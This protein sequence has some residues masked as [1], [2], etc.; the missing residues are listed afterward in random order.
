MQK[1]ATTTT[2]NNRQTDTAARGSLTTTS[3]TTTTN[4]TIKEL[5]TPIDKSRQQ[6][7]STTSFHRQKSKQQQQQKQQHIEHSVSGSISSNDLTRS[8]DSRQLQQQQQQQQLNGL[9]NTH[10][11]SP[12]RSITSV[13]LRNYSY[14][15]KNDFAHNNRAVIAH[16][17]DE[18][19]QLFATEHFLANNRNDC[20]QTIYNK[21][22]GDITVYK[23]KLDPAVRRQQQNKSSEASAQLGQD[24]QTIN[25]QHGGEVVM[26]HNGSAVKNNSHNNYNNNHCDQ[27]RVSSSK[28]STLQTKSNINAFAGQQHR[29]SN[30]YHYPSEGRYEHGQL[31]ATSRLTPSLSS[32]CVTQPTG[33]FVN[34]YPPTRQMQ[35]PPTS[36][37]QY[38]NYSFH[39][40]LY[41]QRSP[42]SHQQQQ[43]YFNQQHSNQYPS[44]VQSPAFSRQSS[45]RYTYAKLPPQQLTHGRLAEAVNI[46]ESDQEHILPISLTPKP[47][48]KFTRSQT[49]H[50]LSSK[51]PNN[52]YEQRQDPTKLDDD[53]QLEDA[54]DLRRGSLRCMAS[55]GDLLRRDIVRYCDGGRDNPFKPDTEL[56]WEAD[57]MVKLMKRGY[58]IAE[59]TRLVEAAKSYKFDNGNHHP[60]NQR[61]PSRAGQ[62]AET[63]GAPNQREDRRGHAQEKKCN[64]LSGREDLSVAKAECDRGICRR[65]SVNQLDEKRSECKQVWADTLKRTK[66]MPKFT[67]ND[68]DSL[69]KLITSIENEISSLLERDKSKDK[70]K[71]VKCNEK[72]AEGKIGNLYASSRIDN[73]P[74]YGRKTSK[75]DRVGLRSDIET[76]KIVEKSIKSKKESNKIRKYEEKRCCTIQ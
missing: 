52:P 56:S 38:R 16:C 65:S 46:V 72:Q 7:R 69:D 44:R 14:D 5:R 12:L 61:L 4:T 51:T 39:V 63:T 10:Q 21:R 20:L 31:P 76:S 2:L 18:S 70:A 22:D 29:K 17:D 42:L 27:R 23:A 34:Y 67:L 3:T 49:I 32:M 37:S 6:Q 73:Q 47:L 19:I 13:G 68:T 40:P 28:S 25:V 50:N 35:S 33:R 55:E 11:S 8:C 60:Q 54:Y 48:N 45:S 57:I 43:R 1:S 58:P 62:D 75:I 30:P 64:Q 59:L 15:Y 71:D 74:E 36:T 9:R 41:M 24:S 26:R 53:S 66:S